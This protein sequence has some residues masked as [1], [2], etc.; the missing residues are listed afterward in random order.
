VARGLSAGLEGA[1]TASTLYPIILIEANLDS[2]DILM[3][4]GVG[5]LVYDGKTYLGAGQVLSIGEV[6]ETQSVEAR[7]ASFTLSGVPSSLVS[8]ALAENYQNRPVKMYLAALDADGVMLGTPYPIFSGKAD[9][10]EVAAGADSASAQTS[11]GARRKIKRQSTRA[12]HS[13]TRLSRYKARTMF[14]GNNEARTPPELAFT[15]QGVPDCPHGH[16]L[17]VGGAGLRTLCGG[18]S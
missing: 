11:A 8:L 5:D 12:I 15:S 4:S 18:C 1:V 2:G 7:G 14:G 6:V 16:A 17:R 10:M 3:W 13:L 9:V